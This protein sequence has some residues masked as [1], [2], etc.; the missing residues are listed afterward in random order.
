MSKW[1]IS[2]KVKFQSTLP[3]LGATNSVI[4]LTGSSIISIHAPLT[5]S[6]LALYPK[7]P[8]SGYFN[9][10]SPYGERHRVPPCE[11]TAG[12]FNP[13]SPYGERPIGPTGTDPQDKFQSTLPLRG[14]TNDRDPTIYAEGISIH[15]PLTGSDLPLAV[16]GVSQLDFN[17]R[18]PYGERHPF[19]LQ[20]PIMINFNPRSPYGERL[21]EYVWFEDM[22]DIS[23][24]APLTGSDLRMPG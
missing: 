19:I 9:P 3:L 18:S 21:L 16:D 7:V 2:K 10:R 1:K 22:T 4:A 5:G 24:H 11:S 12:D 17:P 14:A 23:I 6:D 13:R 8:S 15:A 20:K